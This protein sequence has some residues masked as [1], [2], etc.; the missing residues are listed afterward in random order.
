MSGG[1]IPEITDETHVYFMRL[2]LKIRPVKL[3]NVLD[4]WSLC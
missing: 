1:D 4:F 3:A 2:D